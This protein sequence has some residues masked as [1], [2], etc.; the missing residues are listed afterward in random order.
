MKIVKLSRARKAMYILS[1]IPLVLL[2]TFPLL[3]VWPF[4]DIAAWQAFLPVGLIFLGV[5]TVPIAL[6]FDDWPK[7]LWLWGNDEEGCPAWWGEQALAKGGFIKRFPRWWWYVVRNPVNNLRY[8]FDDREANYSGNW[9]TQEMEAHSLLGASILSAYRWAFNGAF[10]GY[11]SVWINPELNKAG[12]ITYSEFWIGW[13]PGSTV[14]GMG[15]TM[16]Y[17]RNRELGK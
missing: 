16:Q 10:A 15:F 4:A 7:L 11:R 8:V 1:W 5:I 2:H 6:L 12:N 14:P 9:A 17:R 13:K 3:M